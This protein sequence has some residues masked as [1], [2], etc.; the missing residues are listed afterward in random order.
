MLF[1]CFNKFLKEYLKKECEHDGFDSTI[2]VQTIDG[3][4][5]SVCRTPRAD[6]SQL[7]QRLGEMFDNESFPY[8]HVVV[9]EAQ[10]FGTIGSRGE[11]YDVL[12]NIKL[13]IEQ[14]KEGTFFLFY[15]RLQMVQANS[16]PSVIVDADCKLTLYENCRNTQNIAKASVSLLPPDSRRRPSAIPSKTPIGPAPIIRLATDG[17]VQKCV[18]DA[19]RSTR[20]DKLVKDIVILTCKTEGTSALSGLLR[21]D[22]DRSSFRCGGVDHFVT[23]C[24]KFKGLEADAVIL[25]DV[26]GTSLLDELGELLF[27]V[28]SSRARY[29]LEIVT[30][31]TESD[32]HTFLVQNGKAQ[33]PGREKVTFLN[34]IN[35]Q[36]PPS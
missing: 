18:E 30:T 12:A 32:I 14:K 28:G 27:Y 8:D 36:F 9:D 11:C 31:A 29:H 25:V 4:A 3:F 22:G 13:C 20:S 17:T 5:C 10:D 23:T 21:T 16:L 19:I 34:A 15:D 6:Y 26:D 1:L 2:D 35:C 24:R 7:I 33:R